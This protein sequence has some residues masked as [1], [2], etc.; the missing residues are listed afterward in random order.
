MTRAACPPRRPTSA[1]PADIHVF[2]YEA[3]AA[4]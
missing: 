1:D 4:E 2:G 3:V